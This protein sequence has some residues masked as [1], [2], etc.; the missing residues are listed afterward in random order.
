MTR[1][2]G[3]S[4][5]TGSG[6]SLEELLLSVVETLEALLDVLEKLSDE[7]LSGVDT[8][9]LLISEELLSGVDTSELLTLSDELS[10]V[11][12]TLLEKLLTEEPLTALT[13]SE[14]C[15]ADDPALLAPTLITVLVPELSGALLHPVR[16]AH[17][18]TSDSAAAKNLDFLFINYHSITV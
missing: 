7:L 16:P 13:V 18:I 8:L 4:G 1:S 11:E 14:L 6:S 17:I 10:I 3:S 12:K 15:M 2:I 5:R 9:E